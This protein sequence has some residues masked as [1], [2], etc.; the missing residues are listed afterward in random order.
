MAACIAVKIIKGLKVNLEKKLSLN[1]NSQNLQD[2]QNCC[3]VGAGFK[4]AL[5]HLLRTVFHPET[6]EVII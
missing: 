4:P 1:Q 6:I 3:C 5:L 2:F